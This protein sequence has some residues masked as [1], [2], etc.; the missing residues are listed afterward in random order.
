M[1]FNSVNST[2]LLYLLRAHAPFETITYTFVVV[3]SQSQALN[4][5][6]RHLI[7]CDKM[8]EIVLEDKIAIVTGAAQGIG[9]GIALMLA[10]S[11]AKV[12]VVDISDKIDEVVQAISD[13]GSSGLALKCNVADHEEV[14]KVSEKVFEKYGRVDILVNN[15]GIYP[16]KPFVEMTEENWDKVMNVNVKGIFNFTKAVLPKMIERKYGKI[17]NLSSVAGEELGYANLVHYSASKAAI[18][19]FTRSLALEVA[20]Y[21]I[22]VNSI[23]PGAI[24][25]PGAAGQISRELYEQTKNSIPLGRWGKPEDIANTVVFLVSEY[26]SYITG[27][28]IIVDGGLT[29]AP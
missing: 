17:V 22:N 24:E 13:L 3:I 7:V 16:F 27:Q 21:G 25:T 9:R 8:K 11:G 29:I 12:A 19:G 10:E 14:H 5:F 6:R 4:Y 23:C 28:C 15:A 1:F 18:L 2:F 26:A 20:R